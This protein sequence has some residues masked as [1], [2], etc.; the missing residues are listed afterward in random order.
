MF[1]PVKNLAERKYFPIISKQK[2]VI[3]NLYKKYLALIN[4]CETGKP[5]CVQY[6]PILSKLKVL[7]QHAD[8]LKTLYMQEHS[9]DPNEFNNFNKGKF[10]RN[11]ELF[12]N[13]VHA[14]QFILYH[15][16][17]GVSSPLVNKIKNYKTSAFDIVLANIFSKYSSR[18]KG[19][20]LALLYRSVLIEKYG[21]KEILQL[22]LD[23][24]KILGT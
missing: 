13:I 20:Q 18:L 22:L 11:N 5:N 14:I 23:A 2:T 24:T 21:Y 12:S 6:I 16:D 17:F 4:D 3:L 1:W 10:Y 7:L 9:S 8:L 15:I 19:T